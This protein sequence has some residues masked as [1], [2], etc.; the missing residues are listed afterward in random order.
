MCCLEFWF[1][2]LFDSYKKFIKNYNI[3]KLELIAEIKEYAKIFAD[4]FD[5]EI[6]D[7]QLSDSSS[8][9]RI[10]AIIFGLENT[11]L[12][13][14]VLFVLKNV[15]DQQEQSKIFD[16]LETYIMRRMVC[17]ANTKNYN[18]LFGE[19]FISNNILT[20]DDLKIFID[21]RSD[22]VN[23]MPSDSELKDGFHQSKLTNKQAAGILYFIESK[24]RDRAKHSTSLLGLVRYSLEHLMPKKWENHWGKLSN[25]QEKINRSFQPQSTPLPSRIRNS[26]V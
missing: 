9:E 1:E 21:K 8:I 18:Q 2:G 19:R 23:F 22:K 13:P 20:K 15:T 25:E 5:I 11:T 17:H 26:F 10:N 24:I 7:S 14:Y 16:Y 4:N 12:I 3:N 6:I